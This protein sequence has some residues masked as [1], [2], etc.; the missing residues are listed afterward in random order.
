MINRISYTPYAQTKT[1]FKGEV[2]DIDKAIKR[3]SKQDGS[4]I[5]PNEVGNLGR[6]IDEILK[7]GGEKA[8][9][10]KKVIKGTFMDRTEKSQ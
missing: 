6:K 2:K 1:P 10:L 8:D 3:I 5:S 9:R 7:K 4:E